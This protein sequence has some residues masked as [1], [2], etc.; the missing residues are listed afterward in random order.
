MA[1]D[2]TRV[3]QLKARYKTPKDLPF[4]IGKLGHIVINCTDIER[5]LKFYTEVLGFECSDIYTDDMAPGG[6]AFL[7]FSPDHHSIA[8]VGS[9]DKSRP[10]DNYELNHIAFEVATL[11]EVLRAR[12]HLKKHGVKLDFEGRRRAG[13]QIA[14]EFHD[15]DNHRLEIFWGLDQLAPGQKA[16]PSEEWKWAHS[17]EEAI[18]N[19]VK[20]QDTRLKDKALMRQLSDAEIA[21]LRDHSIATQTKK[22]GGGKVI[23]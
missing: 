19:P 2:R 14:V 1:L 21:A 6:M 10:S 12:E 15:P 7:R 3:E 9:M 13:A 4:K 8:L 23:K 5:S 22:L 17:L 18:Q 16:R 11:D 20:G